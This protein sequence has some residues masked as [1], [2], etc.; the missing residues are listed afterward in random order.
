VN[1]YLG[2]PVHLLQYIRQLFNMVDK[3][4]QGFDSNYLLPDCLIC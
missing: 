1:R 3:L 2:I 4:V